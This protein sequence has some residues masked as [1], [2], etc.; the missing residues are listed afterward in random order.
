MGGTKAPKKDSGIEV[1]VKSTHQRYLE[2]V[3]DPDREAPVFS[4]SVNPS[5]AVT[6]DGYIGTDP[7]YQNHA[8]DTDEPMQAD[9]GPDK[10]AEDAYIDSVEGEPTEAGE[11]LK[12]HFADLTR[13]ADDSKAKDEADDESDDEAD[14]EGVV[15]ASPGTNTTS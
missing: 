10:L 2:T 5:E 15:P 8:N 9:E 14:D 13:T 1:D 6:S 11:A 7:I 3:L 4:E 12:G